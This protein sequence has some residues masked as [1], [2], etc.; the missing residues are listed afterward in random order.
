M[1]VRVSISKLRPDLLPL[2]IEGPGF[3]LQNFVVGSQIV[4]FKFSWTLAGTQFVSK[5]NQCFS[6]AKGCRAAPFRCSVTGHV[7]I[8]G[9]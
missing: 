3:P 9:K 5:G 7:A 8:K 4:S 6:N 2:V 1:T